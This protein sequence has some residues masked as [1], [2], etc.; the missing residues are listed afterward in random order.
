MAKEENILNRILWRY[1]SDEE[2][3]N[4]QRQIVANL[5]P[6]SASVSSRWI[7]RGLNNPEILHWLRSVEESAPET[8]FQNLFATAERELPGHRFLR[9]QEALEGAMA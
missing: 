5:S 3:L 1:Y 7:M 6:W 8:V 9:I 2:I 4:I